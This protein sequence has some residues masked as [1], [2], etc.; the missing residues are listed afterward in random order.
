MRV[1][2]LITFLLS[3]PGYAA[4]DLIPIDPKT[5]KAYIRL[6]DG[7]KILSGEVSQGQWLR[8]CQGLGQNLLANASSPGFLAEYS[9]QREVKEPDIADSIPWR[10]SFVPRPKFIDITVEFHSK[11]KWISVQTFS[12]HLQGE[13]LEDMQKATVLRFLARMIVESLP[14]GWIYTHK[15]G[16]KTLELIMHPD[17]PYLPEELLIY[18]LNYKPSKKLWVPEVKASLVRK[19]AFRNLEQGRA[20]TFEWKRTYGKL[21]EGERYW[22]QNSKG[23]NQRQAEYEKKINGETQGFSLLNLLDRMLFESFTSNYAGLRWG[24]SFVQGESVITDISL[25]SALLEI[26]SG[27]LSGLRFY[28][29]LTPLAEKERFGLVEHF[30]MSRTSLGWAWEII[31]P[32]SWQGLI[33][34][35]DLQPKFGILSFESKLAV[36]DIL[37]E[38]Q[39]TSFEARRVLNLNAE[40]GIEK[41]SIGWRTRLWGSYSSAQASLV[42]S[43]GVSVTSARLGFDVYMDLMK[44]ENWELKALAFGFGERL[45][46]ERDTKTI[47]ES[48]SDLAIRQFGFNLLFIGG[49]VTVSW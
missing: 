21:L 12:F 41:E 25:I 32:E 23:R 36:Q 15:S 2:W 35:I 31:P 11:D 47:A 17:M 40:L 8:L 16:G 28:Y 45:L 18:Q 6:L 27:P 20:E 9:C 13:F 44:K 19:Q 22:I 7:E 1:F 37:G 10:I 4:E 33:S 42:K 38:Y 39:L 24:R 3:L 5:Q 29:D 46:L 43:D 48:S 14:S 49:G 34:R 30:E 26:R